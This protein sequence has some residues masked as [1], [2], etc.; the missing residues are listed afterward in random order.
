MK[1]FK[2][3]LQAVRILRE[4]EEQ[5]ALEEYANAVRAR[6]LAFQQVENARFEL[7]EKWTEL[8]LKLQNGVTA[9]ELSQLHIFCKALQ[10]K[11]A[12]AEECLRKAK[13]HA[14]LCW[15]KLM[16]ARQKRE[17]VDK[18]FKKQLLKYQKEC[19]RDEQKLIDELSIRRSPI[20]DNSLLK[21]DLNLNG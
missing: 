3:T 18:Y 5:A 17:T 1:P 19:F 9:G 20:K 13:A 7:Q 11:L 16:T 6:Q 10:N 14:H 15:K 21:F 8:N 2:F 4:R 12:D